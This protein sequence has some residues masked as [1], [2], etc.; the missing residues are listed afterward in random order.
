MERETCFLSHVFLDVVVDIHKDGGVTF[1][2][3]SSS[4]IYW[5]NPKYGQI[6][7]GWGASER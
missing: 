7:C 5:K 3:S 2:P 6:F 4:F 1:S